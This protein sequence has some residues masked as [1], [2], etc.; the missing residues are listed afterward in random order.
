MKTSGNFPLSEEETDAFLRQA[1]II[2]V[3]SQGLNGR[4]NL[5]PLWFCW[6]GGKIYAFTRGQKIRN[7]R[8]D[9]NCTMMVDRNEHYPELQ[10]VMLVGTVRVLEDAAAEAADEHLDSMVRDAMGAKYAM[11]GFGTAGSSRNQSTA[12]GDD[13]R[14]IVFTPERGFSWDNKKLPQRAPKA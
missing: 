11:G 13:W 2:R 1:K 8:R 10:G 14:W 4:I 6:A 12:M 7:L 3:A 9:P 5:A